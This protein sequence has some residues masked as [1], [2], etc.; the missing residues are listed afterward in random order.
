M[1]DGGVR[2]FCENVEKNITS[3]KT[4]VEISGMKYGKGRGGAPKRSEK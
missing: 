2:N 3:L 1:V 4:C